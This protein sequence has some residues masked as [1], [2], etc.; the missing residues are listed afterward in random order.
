MEGKLQVISLIPLTIHSLKLIC[1]DPE[2]EFHLHYVDAP[3]N[4]S[5][6]RGRQI[7]KLQY[8]KYTS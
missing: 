1:S 6:G 5:K 2:P 3:E 4:W 7:T 8:L